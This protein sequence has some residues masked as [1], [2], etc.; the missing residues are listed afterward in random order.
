MKMTLHIDGSAVTLETLSRKAQEVSFAL[1]GKTYVFR[2]AR[3]PD[4][5]FLLERETAPGV[6]QR[7]SG[8]AWAG[9]DFKRVQLGALEAKISELKAG[10][11]AAFS[12]AALSPAAPMPGVI[13]Q[14]LVKAGDKVSKNQPLIIME[15]MKLQTT[16][17]AGGD[18]VV[19]AVLVKVGDMVAEGAELVRI[20]PLL[21]AGGAGGG[22]Q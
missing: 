13:R 14:V 6:W 22:K 2:S 4:G 17:Y 1:N 21:H 12:E 3:L 9:K 7:L 19:E 16:L 10:A 5:S 18:G 15:A 11:S 20:A 8:Q